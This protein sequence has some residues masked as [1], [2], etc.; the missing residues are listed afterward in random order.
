MDDVKC[1]ALIVAA[2]NWVV[3]DFVVL[4]SLRI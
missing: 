2:L 4:E 3:S 1:S